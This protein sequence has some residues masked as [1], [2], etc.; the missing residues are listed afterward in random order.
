MTPV[1]HVVKDTWKKIKRGRP[2]NGRRRRK[3][4]KANLRYRILEIQNKKR[5]NREILLNQIN[6]MI[7]NN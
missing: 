2:L 5:S 6:I 3:K 7:K 4:M 1:L